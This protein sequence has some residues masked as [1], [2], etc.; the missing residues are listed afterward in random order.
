MALS[1]G[2]YELLAIGVVLLVLFLVIVMFVL[3]R[4]RM[5]RLALL[6]GTGAGAATTADR[7]YN[8]LA[9][10][11]READLLD[12]QGGDSTNAR[13]L[14]DLA[15]R[16]LDGH[17]YDRAYELAQ[18][19]HETL[20]RGRRDA[21]LRRGG[22]PPAPASPA[23]ALAPASA[24]EPAPAPAAPV[25]KNRVEAQF[26]LRL[27]DQDLSA[28]GPSAAGGAAGEARAL[29]GQAHAAFDRGEYGEAFRLALRGRRRI[30]ATVEALGPSARRAAEPS[31]PADPAQAAEAAAAGGRCPSCGH[32]L[33]AG[34]AFCRGCG[35]PTGRSC[36]SCGAPLRAPDTFCGRCGKSTT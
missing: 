16:S 15:N 22:G 10:A 9:L 11:R 27:L 26:E 1:I 18:S 12:S 6:R 34:D 28:G 13:Q 36:P 5:R 8:R 31:L 4:Y 24:A 33:V 29:A 35:A 30:G 2:P 21:P 23:P 32:P 3:R 19:A 7:A 25:A 17:Q 14:I 20:V